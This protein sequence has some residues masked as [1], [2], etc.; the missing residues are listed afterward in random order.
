MKKVLFIY[1]YLYECGHV[2][3]SS[4]RRVADWTNAFAAMSTTS[5]SSYPRVPAHVNNVAGLQFEVRRL[6]RE[7]GRRIHHE[8]FRMIQ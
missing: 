6:A 4:P 5:A 7:N 8:G 3:A 2:E 1:S